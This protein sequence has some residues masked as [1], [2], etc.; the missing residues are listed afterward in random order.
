[1][2]NY[3][4]VLLALLFM[5]SCG[6]NA[7]GGFGEPNPTD[8]TANTTGKKGAAFS[9][10]T[11]AWS[12]K[13]SQ[14]GAHWM[15]SWG[16]VVR[17]EI[18][19]N[20][21][22]VP[23]FW[24]AG[25]VNQDNI[26]RIKQLADAGKVKFVLGFNEPDG[27][28]QAN[29]TVDEAIALWP[30]LEEIGVPLVSPAT[31]SPNNDWMK[32]FMKRADELKLRV[33]YVAV[34]HYGGTNVL[35]FINKL[36][37]TYQAYNRPIWVTEFAVADWNATAPDN[38]K[39]SEAAVKD[40]MKEALTALDDIDWV[41]RY[42]WFDGKNAPL[43]TSALFDADANITPLGEF[44]AGHK[45]NADIGPG[46]DTEFEPPADPGELLV[47]GGFESGQIAPWQGFK[48]GVVTSATTEPHTGKFCGRIENGDGSLFYV[49]DVKPDTTYTLRFFSKWNEVV[50]Q[51][52][53]G[54]I[55]NNVDNALIYSLA[56]MPMTDK[57]EE[58]VYEFT[59]PADV[60][61]LK[62]VF[63]KAQGFPPFFMDDVSLKVKE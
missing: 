58:T 39:Y 43:Y 28:S 19:E 59:V 44:Y 18:P 12:H 38:N 16:N 47:N 10:T 57:W 46:V 9:N 17:D 1:M 56:D 27:A 48:N 37:E 61:Q 55:R 11:L 24:G 31:V 41:Y 62:M 3:I 30:R 33:D 23:M 15:Y 51:S 8:N 7:I 53:S 6:K 22:F 20:V 50:S 52:F 34:H 40:F 60:N 13:T 26:D 25:S 63:Y 36:K 5:V 2:K 42:A 45:P 35:S 32:E 4:L 21:E 14:L 29:M 54:K 49:V